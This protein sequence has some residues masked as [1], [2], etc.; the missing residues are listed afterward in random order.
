MSYIQDHVLLPQVD[1]F[2]F[3]HHKNYEMLFSKIIIF[4]I[5][6]IATNLQVETIIMLNKII[7]IKKSI[8]LAMLVQFLGYLLEIVRY[9]MPCWPY[10]ISMKK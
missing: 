4:H 1:F 9:E 5:G 3:F 6:T 2:S 7:Q 10:L 8:K